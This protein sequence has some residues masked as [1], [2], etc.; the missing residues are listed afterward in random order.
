VTE[1]SDT[2]WTG[3]G[4]GRDVRHGQ[5]VWLL[6]VAN[7]IEEYIFLIPECMWVCFPDQKG[8]HFIAIAL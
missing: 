4:S 8:I 2:L 6:G 5:S 7:E 1:S 3:L